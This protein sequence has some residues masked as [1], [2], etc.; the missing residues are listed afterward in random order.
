MLN[1]YCITIYFLLPVFLLSQW[2]NNP[3]VNNVICNATYQQIDPKIVPDGAG[4]AIIVWEDYR[5]DPLQSKGDI[6]A[7]RITKN[8]IVKW[9]SNGLA[10]C[11][12]SAHQSNP[13]IDY[14]NGRVVIIWNDYR[15]G[16]ADIYAQMID[17]S[18]N[19]LWASGGVPVVNISYAQ[20]DGR[21]I[22]DNAW[23]S[24]IVYQDSSAGNW[25]IYAQKLNASG[26]Q[27][28]SS[29]GT[30]VCN[31]GNSQ[32]NPRA[33]L[34][35]SGELY[36]V[37][38]DK[39]SG[40]YDIYAQKLNANG[41]RQWNVASNGIW[42]CSVIGAQT[43]PKIEPFGS[44]FITAWIDYRN[45][46]NYDIY[47]QYINNN[48]AAQWASNGI[49]VCN[50][51]GNQSALDL[52][53]NRTDG[54]YVVWK[55]NRNGTNYDIYMQKITYAGAI[56][57]ASNGILVSGAANDQ[58]NPN[59]EVDN[60][61]NALVV[62]QDSSAGNWN[63]SAAKVNLSGAILWNTVVT[64]A[65]SS[66]TDPKNVSDDN[67]GTIVVWK[68][69]RN[70][71]LSQWDIYCQRIFQNGSLDGISENDFQ[72]NILIGPVPA[73][74]F[75]YVHLK[76]ESDK[77]YQIRLNDITGK[78]IVRS[79][80]FKNSCSLS[81]KE[82]TSGIYFLKIYDNENTFIYSSKVIKE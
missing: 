8:G 21:V 64:N 46:S 39:R 58:I 10:V 40:E 53:D 63:I 55:D 15:N 71:T 37:W 73:N 14:R 68:D 20:N 13:N 18:G 22:I 44:G 29:S 7:Q 52:K 34:N 47:A 56:G 9:T 76:S 65:A 31:A 43:N 30:V 75:I 48:G 69:K 32:I 57:W 66:Q 6:Y 38:Q 74:D 27:Q 70:N 33:E 4:G 79:S 35:L 77:G 72:S 36:V 59:V 67:G 25:D 81:L 19:V 42:V 82:F 1:K 11:S 62:W 60:A 41:V 45:G 50:A 61:G 28:W 5:N 26:I 49:M 3:S 54:A 24:Y 78:E 80:Y 16:Y 2:S 17:T 12:H 23:N 51:A